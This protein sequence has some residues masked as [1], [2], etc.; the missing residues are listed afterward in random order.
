MCVMCDVA[1]SCQSFT[2]Q[3]DGTDTCSGLSK[4]QLGK[5]LRDTIADVRYLCQSMS[6][7]YSDCI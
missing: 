3:V 5:Q 4:V 2:C 1:G 7:P 6:L